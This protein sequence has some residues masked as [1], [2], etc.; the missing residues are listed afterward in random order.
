MLLYF[1][2]IFL[3]K[4]IDNVKLLLYNFDIVKEKEVNT[5]EKIKL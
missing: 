1:F 4:S 3:Q 5:N 2:K